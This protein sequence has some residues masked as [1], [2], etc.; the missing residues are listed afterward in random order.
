MHS[1][2]FHILPTFGSILAI[3]FGHFIWFCKNKHKFTQVLQPFQ[4]FKDEL[5]IESQRDW[6]KMPDD[7]CKSE[8]AVMKLLTLKNTCAFLYVCKAGE[9]AVTGEE[10]KRWWSLA[11]DGC[12]DRPDLSYK[13]QL[14]NGRE[15]RGRRKSFRG[16][17]E[18]KE[19]EGGGSYQWHAEGLTTASWQASWPK[20]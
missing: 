2:L 3:F 8:S 20:I 5:S 14:D 9:A 13:A 4:Y 15:A 7:L 12:N 1:R 6:N 10:E 11:F 16:R 19:E 18:E 17:E